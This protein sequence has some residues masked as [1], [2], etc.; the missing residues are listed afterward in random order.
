MDVRQ[1]LSG[2][3]ENV[4]AMLYSC[5]YSFA[6]DVQSRMVCLQLFA[7]AITAMRGNGPGKWLCFLKP[8]MFQGILYLNIAVGKGGCA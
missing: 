3:M 7:V 6:Q 4:R 1:L 8:R 2:D 5:G